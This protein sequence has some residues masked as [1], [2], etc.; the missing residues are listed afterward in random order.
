MQQ[1]SIFFSLIFLTTPIYAQ[2]S[3]FKITASDATEGEQYGYSSGIS[4]DYAVVGAWLDDDSVDNVGSAYVYKRIGESW[5]QETKLLSSDR[6]AGDFFGTSVS[7]SGDFIVVGV[8]NDDDNGANSGSAYIF[9]RSDIGWIQ[10]A[11]LLPSDGAESD[12][13]GW[14][15]SISGDYTVVGAYQDDDNG[16]SSGSA[17]VFKRTGTIWNQEAKILP[18]DGAEI[19]QFGYSVSI[20]GDYLVVG[21][22]NDKQNGI[23]AGAAYVFKRTVTNWI[24]EAKLLPSDGAQIEGFGISVAISGNYIVIGK[25]FDSYNGTASGSAYIF[26]LSGGS[27]EEETKLL[28]SDGKADDNFG[29]AVSISGGYAVVTSRVGAAY[30]FNDSAGTWIQKKILIPSDTEEFI[31]FG[32][33]VSID[34]DNI[35]VGSHLDDEVGINSGSAYIYGG[36]TPPISIDGE[37]ARLTSNFSLYQNYPN[38]FNPITNINYSLSQSGDVILVIYNL[39]GEEVFRFVNGIQSAGE[40]NISWNASN[41]ASGIYFYR[42]QAGDFV[43]IRKMLL[44]K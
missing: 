12:D 5:I 44:L 18:S 20:S 34:G 11:K 22:P 37:N 17:Y 33:S 14:S 39:L 29:K 6:E 31:G 13:F 25:S 32:R 16:L 8:K 4:G 10:E 23:A 41:F 38:P 35:I 30:I 42:L 24:Q 28:P 26:K 2:I 40:Y 21:A 15:V 19:A 1:L 36:F 9:K 3:E 43:Q 7:I 27:W